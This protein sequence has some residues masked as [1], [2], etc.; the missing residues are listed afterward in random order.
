MKDPIPSGNWVVISFGI[1]RAKN[2]SLEYIEDRGYKIGTGESYWKKSVTVQ[3]S[4][5]NSSFT[6]IVTPVRIQSN[7]PQTSFIAPDG[8]I[9]YDY[10]TRIFSFTILAVNCV[11]WFN[12]EVFET[13][14][15]KETIQV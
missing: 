5:P 13:Y 7:Y 11:G 2:T 8:G 6:L 12:W 10:N 4:A 3:W 15:G 1:S 14:R 9:Y